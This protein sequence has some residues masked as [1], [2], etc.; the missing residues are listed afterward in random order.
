M[1]HRPW[2]SV[3]N[4]GGELCREMTHHILPLA[5]I[6]HVFKER[7]SVNMCEKQC[8]PLMCT[9]SPE[10][11]FLVVVELALCSISG[12]DLVSGD[13][14]VFPDISGRRWIGGE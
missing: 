12:V 7:I 3:D 2:I 9:A 13:M 8:L 14:L 6:S 11:T 5:P 1:Q 4:P 10:P